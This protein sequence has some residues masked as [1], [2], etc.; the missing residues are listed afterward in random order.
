MK[1]GDLIRVLPARPRTLGYKI[2]GQLGVL[3]EELYGG[4]SLYLQWRLLIGGA[5]YWLYPSEL[6]VIDESR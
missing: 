2:G 3:I 1:V 4:G 6:E 5:V